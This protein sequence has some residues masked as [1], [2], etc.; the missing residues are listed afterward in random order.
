MD[1][2]ACICSEEVVEALAQCSHVVTSVPP[3]GL[4]LYDPVSQGVCE[5]LAGQEL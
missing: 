3:V 4:P 1:L 2:A 5:L